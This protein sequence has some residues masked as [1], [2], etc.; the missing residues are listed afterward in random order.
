M[1]KKDPDYSKTIIYRIICKNPSITDCYVGHTT[2]FVERKCQHKYN[3]NNKKTKSYVYQF[4]RANGGWEN[5]DIVEIEKYPCNDSNEALKRERYN[6][7]LYNA[8]LNNNIPS[9]TMKEWNNDNKEYQKEYR[10]NNKEKKKEYYENN[11]DKIKLYHKIY[12]LKKKIWSVEHEDVDDEYIDIK[13]EILSDLK[14]Q[15]NK[16][17]IESKS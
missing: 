16:L 17:M 5:W 7:E 9:R 13:K 14:S 10:E 15:L 12:T 6:F 3:C 11:K 8:T 2:N 1:P 4:I